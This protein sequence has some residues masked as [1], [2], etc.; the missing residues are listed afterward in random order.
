MSQSVLEGKTVLAVDDEPDIL[1]ILEEEIHDISPECKVE[2]A[3]TFQEAE[4]ALK[5][6]SYDL[7]VVDL[8][9]VRGF[10]LLERITKLG[11][12]AVVLTAHALS[13]ETLIRSIQMGARA[14]IPKDKLAEIVPFLE[15]ALTCDFVTGWRRLLQRLRG[16]FDL[17][18]GVDWHKSEADFWKEFQDK[19]GI[20][21]WIINR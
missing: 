14:Y 20:E 5:R 4:S 2:R 13:S 16:S 15:E 19:V 7:V 12:P 17:H 8:M 1:A 21:K 3:T 11:I 9:G 6:R 18:F 10:E